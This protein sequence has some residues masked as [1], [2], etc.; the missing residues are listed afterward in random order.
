MKEFCFVTQAKYLDAY[1]L[2]DIFKNCNKYLYDEGIN[3]FLNCNKQL[4]RKRIHTKK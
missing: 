3:T 1:R 2:N 4:R